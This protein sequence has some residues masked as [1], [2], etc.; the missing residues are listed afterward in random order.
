[1]PGT[2]FVLFGPAHLGAL[3]SIA[4]AAGLAVPFARHARASRVRALRLA[5]AAALAASYVS[6]IAGGALEGWLSPAILPLQ[7]CDVAGLLSI[8]T[9]VTLGRRTVGPLYYVALAGTLPA[10]V[11]PE[12]GEGFPSLRF[13]A[14]F[15]PHGLIVTTAL[16]LPFGLRLVPPRGAWLRAFVLLNLY[17]LAVTPVNLALGTNF[18]YLRAK[19]IG[20]T[21]YDWF[22]PWPYYILTEEFVAASVFFLLDL[23]LRRLRRAARA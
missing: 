11:T 1:M 22:G 18:L 14:Y 5:M 7:L 15:L 20:P 3:A 2:R 23:P 6:E 17:A 16:L 8:W 13:A 10:I 12:L 9:L 4:V 19:P 21:P